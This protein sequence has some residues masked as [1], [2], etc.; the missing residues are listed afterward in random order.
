[1][2]DVFDLNDDDDVTINID[3]A[4]PRHIMDAFLVISW[5]H[6]LQAKSKL[7]PGRAVGTDDLN[8]KVVQCLSMRGVLLLWCNFN[9]TRGMSSAGQRKAEGSEAQ[10]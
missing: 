3:R 6:F 2:C 9:V 7:K 5:R 1:M 10:D 8:A 4:R